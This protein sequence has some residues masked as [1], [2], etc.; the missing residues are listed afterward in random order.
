MR[1]EISKSA[2][3]DIEN[4]TETARVAVL[5]QIKALMQAETL[6]SMGNVIKMKGKKKSVWYRLKIDDFRIMIE[7]QD[8][9]IV[10]RTVSDRKDVYKKR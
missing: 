7:K 2:D 1:V 5:G 10:I 3:K 4:L 9:Q 6:G 8:T